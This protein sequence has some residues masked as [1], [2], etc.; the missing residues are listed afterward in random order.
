MSLGGRRLGTELTTR[1]MLI[2]RRRGMG[3]TRRTQLLLEPA[4]HRRLVAIARLAGTKLAPDKVLIDAG[5]S[6]S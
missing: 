3:L 2:E 5:G 4:E 1:A 6:A